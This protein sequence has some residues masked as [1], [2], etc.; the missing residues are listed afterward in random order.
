[1]K[2]WLKDKDTFSN[3]RLLKELKV[4][5]P[6][7][8]KNFMRMDEET[9]LY[10]LD[11]VKPLIV[12]QDTFM[13]DAIN[14]ETRLS[15]TLRFLATGNSFEDLKFSNAVSAQSIGKIVIE[16]CEAIRKVLKDYIKVSF[17]KIISCIIFY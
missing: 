12:K 15:I 16:T 14:E 5:Q 17:T 4:S 1:M 13:R 9:F 6:D 3:Q 10:L 7:D 2:S 11:K 8:F